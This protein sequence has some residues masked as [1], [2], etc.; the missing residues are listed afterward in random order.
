MTEKSGGGGGGWPSSWCS[1]VRLGFVNSMTLQGCPGGSGFYESLIAWK[2]FVCAL[3]S[4]EK[5]LPKTA[6]DSQGVAPRA[7]SVWW[8]LEKA[9]EL[10]MCKAVFGVFGDSCVWICLV[11]LPGRLTE[12]YQSCSSWN[13]T[14]RWSTVPGGSSQYITRAILVFSSCKGGFQNL[15]EC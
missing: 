14:R 9:P 12:P 8:L 2:T 15:F 6:P 5:R 4:H 13:M 1:L 3:Y 11:R 7:S 10:L